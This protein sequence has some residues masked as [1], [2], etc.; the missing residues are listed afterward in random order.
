ML[1]CLSHK[2]VLSLHLQLLL[3]LKCLLLQ[4]DI[5]SDLYTINLYNFKT[6]QDA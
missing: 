4:V 5:I 3:L 2:M 6:Q 1:T